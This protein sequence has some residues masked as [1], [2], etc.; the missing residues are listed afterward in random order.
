MHKKSSLVT[1]ELIPGVAF[2]F[3]NNLRGQHLFICY[4]IRSK[5]GPIIR[6]LELFEVL[7]KNKR[8]AQ[9]INWK[10]CTSWE[11]IGS[12]FCRSLWCSKWDIWD[13]VIA[14]IVIYASILRYHF[15]KKTKPSVHKRSSLVTG[16]LIPGLV[17]EFQNNLRGQDLFIC[18]KI[19]SKT[20]L[21]ILTLD[22]FWVLYTNQTSIALH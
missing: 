12:H 9:N 7:Y 20:G 8:G 5:K 21:R 13:Y 15:E 2:E 11:C 10:N 16:E 18:Y 19:W 14:I 4:K 6:T 17:F 1:P 22:V 3:Q